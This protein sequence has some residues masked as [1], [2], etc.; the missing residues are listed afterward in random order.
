[1][2]VTPALATVITSHAKCKERVAASVKEL[3]SLWENLFSIFVT[4]I[5]KTTDINLENA[6]AT[7][8]KERDAALQS[9]GRSSGP[10][11][12]KRKTRDRL[13][14]ELDGP[15]GSQIDG[16][17]NRGAMDDEHGSE[18]L[19]QS[20]EFKRRRVES[21]IAT[22]HP[23]KE[24]G[25]DLKDLLETM[26]SS[27]VMHSRVLELLAK[28]KQLVS[29][30]VSLGSEELMKPVIRMPHLNQIIACR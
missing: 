14:D 1:M 7:L 18:A 23:V 15:M 20:P 13:W 12:L 10:L 19:S 22:S 8:H 29:G 11:L 2:A 3:D 16:N 4:N 9:Y 6:I 27:F 30:D 17:G 24:E 26:K 25:V 21:P 28:E 5:V